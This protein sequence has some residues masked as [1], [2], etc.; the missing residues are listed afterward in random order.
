VATF[1]FAHYNTIVRSHF[2]LFVVLL[3]DVAYG[4]VSQLGKLLQA[5]RL[6]PMAS[7]LAN[8]TLSI[9]MQCSSLNWRLQ[10]SFILR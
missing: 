3:V 6:M 10:I 2:S 9:T 8:I 5:S 4:Q 7:H 1:F